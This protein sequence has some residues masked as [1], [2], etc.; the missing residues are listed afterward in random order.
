MQEMIDDF[1]EEP[2]FVAFSTVRRLPWDEDGVVAA[3]PSIYKGQCE[4]TAAMGRL[5]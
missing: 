2:K 5:S 4:T 1:L 3:S